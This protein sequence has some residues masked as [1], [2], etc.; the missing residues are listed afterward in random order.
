MT[1]QQTIDA[2]IAHLRAT[3]PELV[4]FAGAMHRDPA[5]RRVIEEYLIEPTSSESN[6]RVLARTRTAPIATLAELWRALAVSTE[7]LGARQ[8]I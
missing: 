4:H 8:D 5:A 7:H 3:R 6:L 1:D 2:I